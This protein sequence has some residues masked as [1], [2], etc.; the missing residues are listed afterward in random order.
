LS[1]RSERRVLLLGRNGDRFAKEVLAEFPSLKPQLIAPGVLPAQDAADALVAADLC[2]LPFPDGV[3][4]RRSSAMAALALGVPLLTTRGFL[5]ESIWESSGCE[6]V[7]AGDTQ[8][9]TAR[10]DA[11][12]DAPELRNEIAKRG[13]RFYDEQFS[14][15]RTLGVLRERALETRLSCA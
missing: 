4:T 2:V 9:L 13:Q 5:S 1:E 3:T 6:L 10:V 11:L 12:L 7:P 8:R 15:A 14:I